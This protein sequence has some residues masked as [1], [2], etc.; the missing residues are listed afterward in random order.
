[1]ATRGGR[2][3]GTPGKGYS[4]RTDLAMNRAPQQGMETAATGG[5]GMPPQPS[6][7]TPDQ[8]PRLDDPSARPDEPLTHGLS[9][10]AGAGPEALGPMPVNPAVQTIAAA[11]NANPTPELRRAMMYLRIQPDGL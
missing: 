10:G 7:V 8:V 1:M 3:Q 2:R 6:F 11:Y 4:N 5:S 9:L